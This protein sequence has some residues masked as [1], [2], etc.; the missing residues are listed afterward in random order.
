MDARCSRKRE[1]D[2]FGFKS[3][4][5]E[6]CA[7]EE[8]IHLIVDV[9]TT[10]AT[11]PDV[12]Y[13]EAIVQGVRQQG[14][15]PR[16]LLLDSGY[17]SGPLLVR[18]RAQG[19]ELLGPVLP[20]PSWQHREQQGF[21]AAAFEV[22][23]Q[24][25]QVRWPAGQLSC[26]WKSSSDKRG[27]PTITVLFAPTIWQACP[28]HACCTRGSTHGRSLT[29][30]PQSVALALQERRRQQSGPAFQQQYAQR[31]GIEATLSQAV[32]RHDLRKTPYRG[33]SKTH[34]HHVCLASAINLVRIDTFLQAQAQDQPARPPRPPSPFARLRVAA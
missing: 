16:E 17:L 9:Q 2:W 25:Q 23:W 34:L 11:T 14:L 30:P 12:E 19:T 28:L 21:A 5:T 18:Q 4:L 26:R 27:Q 33:L 20:H 6:S 31:A 24:Q 8:P 15:A 10:S 29:L 13:T 32:R 1:V 22:N 7:K 3:H